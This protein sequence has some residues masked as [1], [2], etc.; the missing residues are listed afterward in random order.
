[1][2]TGFLQPADLES[3]LTVRWAIFGRNGRGKTTFLRSIPPDLVFIY[4]T[5]GHERGLR[6]VADKLWIPAAGKK[7]PPDRNLIP[8]VLNRF[9]DLQQ[10]L[11][12]V[13]SLI[14]RGIIHGMA[15]DTLSRVQ[16]LAIGKIMN[17]EPNEPG[18]E[19]QYI[20]RIPKTP[21]GYDHWDQVGALTLEWTRYFNRRPIHQIY[22]LQEQDRE[23]KYDE[24]V[25]TV[26]RLT[27][28][29]YR[30][31]YDDMEMIGRLYVEVAGREV[32]GDVAAVTADEIIK[33]GKGDQHHR[34]IN[35]DA[36]ETRKLFIGQHDRYMCKGDTARL[37]RVIDDPTWAKLTAP[38]QAALPA[39]SN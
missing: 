38:A 7:R 5:V 26:T 9:N 31:L 20:D 30:G 36:V 34:E 32:E 33:D 23:V 12:T 1:M 8:Y 14:D 11:D 37:G 13:D 25:Q 3:L 4:V 10:L 2:P 29:C 24:N 28:A 6:A 22:L 18:T 17:Y 35:P 27:P 21:R 15:W 16:D 19:R 39:S